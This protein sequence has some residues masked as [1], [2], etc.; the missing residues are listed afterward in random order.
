[1]SGTPGI[2]GPKG[3]KGE[4][5]FVQPIPGPAGMVFTPLILGLILLFLD[6]ITCCKFT[7]PR[8]DKGERG[9]DGLPGLPGKP[10][11]LGPQ[12]PPGLTGFKGDKV[13]LFLFLLT[14]IW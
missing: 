9:L 7:G 8:G 6:I 14:K 5:A 1:M 4:S 11:P 12:G 2:P 13:T 3:E 10:G